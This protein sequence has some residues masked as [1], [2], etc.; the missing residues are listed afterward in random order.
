MCTLLAFEEKTP[1]AQGMQLSAKT[2]M[3]NIKA[4]IF[5]SCKGKA[6]YILET[7]QFLGRVKIYAT[8]MAQEAIEQARVGIYSSRNITDI[9]GMLVTKYF[10]S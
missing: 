3:D 10:D 8:D 7:K 5:K 2:R 6:D 4:S 9:P 1:S